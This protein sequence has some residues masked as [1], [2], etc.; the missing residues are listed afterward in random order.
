VKHSTNRQNGTTPQ[1][2]PIPC[3]INPESALPCIADIGATDARLDV[4]R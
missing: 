4:N 1:T 3:R 2:G